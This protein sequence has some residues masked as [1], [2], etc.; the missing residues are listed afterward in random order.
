MHCSSVFA[1]QTVG[2]TSARAQRAQSRPD[3]DGH[4]GNFMFN[5]TASSPAFNAINPNIRRSTS[6]CT[7]VNLSRNPIHKLLKP[8]LDI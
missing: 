7:L 6:Q 4:L 8:Y 1:L 5:V 3:L 2:H